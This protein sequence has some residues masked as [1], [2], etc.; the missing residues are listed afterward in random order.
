MD[1]ATEQHSMQPRD[2]DFALMSPLRRVIFIASGLSA[3][4]GIFAI[5]GWVSGYHLLASGGPNYIPMAPT[6]AIAFVLMGIAL[7]ACTLPDTNRSGRIV[8]LTAVALVSP[9]AALKLLELF[10][11]VPLAGES[12][13]LHKTEAFGAVITGRMS[14]VTALSLLLA[15]VGMA[16]LLWA[17][18]PMKSGATKVASGAA[19]L[20][21]AA[22]LVVIL[23][24]LYGTP[25]L[26][27]GDIIPVALTTRSE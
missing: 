26:Y 15:S 10:I 5:L 25:L 11:R 4:F 16:P 24:Y 17:Q 23:G 12:L 8:G 21:A 14:P 6:T 9:Y 18:G 3:A 22:Y 13:L 2:A 20:L 27:R 19:T 7:S 1:V